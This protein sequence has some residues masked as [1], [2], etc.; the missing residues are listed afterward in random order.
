MN[1]TAKKNLQIT[2]TVDERQLWFLQLVIFIP[3]CLGILDGHSMAEALKQ[4]MDD[5]GPDDSV[6]CVA[7][8]ATRTSKR[9]AAA[10]SIV[11]TRQHL[12]KLVISLDDAEH[13]DQRSSILVEQATRDER[14]QIQKIEHRA[15][16]SRIKERR[17]AEEARI[18]EQHKILE[19]DR[20]SE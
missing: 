15:E 2:T 9:S 17:R 11:R 10:V 14:R 5:I 1:K 13:E 6:R 8:K 3:I 20:R 7:S 12:L 18:E 16:V 4:L 19:A